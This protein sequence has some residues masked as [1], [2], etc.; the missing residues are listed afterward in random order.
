M[1]GGA[2]YEIAIGGTP[3]TYE[4]EAAASARK[5]GGAGQAE[6]RGRNLVLGGG[7]V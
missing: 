5:N 3:R 6:F 4:T 7:Y 2:R 1:S